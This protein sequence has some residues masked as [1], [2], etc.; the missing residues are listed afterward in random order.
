M[1]PVKTVPADLV[2][3]LRD[4]VVRRLSRP[5]LADAPLDTP[6]S[7]LGLDSLDKVE[8]LFEVERLF[9]VAIP[10]AAAAQM[11][12]LADVAAFVANSNGQAG[13]APS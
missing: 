4:L 11:A 13:L 5:D 3:G 12:T 9:N 10:D 2:Q 1:G 6:L 8:L 7:K